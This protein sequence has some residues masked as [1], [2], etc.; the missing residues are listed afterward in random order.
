MNRHIVTGD[1]NAAR[2]SPTTIERREGLPEHGQS[3][4]S[5]QA[6]HDAILDA[7]PTHIATLD[8]RGRINSVNEAW[9]RFGNDNSLSIAECGLGLNYLEICDQTEGDDAAKAQQVAAGIRSVLAGEVD[10]FSTEYACHS[11]S[12][13]RWFLL[14]VIP[15][16]D[17]QGNGALLMHLDVSA[18][19]TAE[20]RLRISELQFRQMAE[21]IRDV[22]FLIDADNDCLLY[23]S[24]AFEAIWGYSCESAYARPKSW[25][26]LIHPEDRASALEKYETHWKGNPTGGYENSYRIVRPDGSCRLI[27]LRAFPVFDDSHKFVRVAGLAKDITELKRGETALREANDFLRSVLDNI[28]IRIFWKDSDSRYLG[29]NTLF[30]RDAGFSTPAEVIGKTDYETTWKAHAVAYRADDQETMESGTS[31]LGYEVAQWT[32]EGNLIWLLVSKVPMCDER[33]QARRI[34]GFYQ[35]ITEE[36]CVAEELDGHRHHLEDLVAKRTREL[37]VARQQ[38]DAANESKTTFLANMSHEIRTPVNAIIGMNHLLRR[39]GVTAEQASRLDKIDSA[40]RHLMS[41]INDILDLSKIEAN[42][43]ELESTDFHLSSVL[44][45]VGSII[46][47]SAQD[48]GLRVEL[49]HDAVPQWLR[50]DPTRLRQALLNYA[51]NAVKFTD[52]GSI[53]VRARLIEDSGSELLIRF[54]VVDTGIGIVPDEIGRVF[55]MFE[56]GDASTTRKYGGTGLGLAITRRLARLMGGDAG[57]E[58]NPGQGSTFWFS[59][60]LQRGHGACQVEVADTGD[61]ELQLSQNF[62][63]ARLLLAEDHPINREVARELLEG[64]GLSVDMAAD[65]EEALNM[66]R[67]FEYDLILMDMQ[68]PKMDGL[69]AT[70]AIRALPGREMT[71][72]LAMTAN[73][74]DDNRLACEAAGMNDFVAKPVEPRLLYRALLKWLATAR[75][76]APAEEMPGDS[77]TV[78]G[79][80]ATAVRAAM[81]VT[82]MTTEAV[83]EL[84]AGVHGLNSARGLA[85]LRGNVEK[86]LKLLGHFFSLH[87]DDMKHLTANL[88]VDD[89][90]SA[91]RLLHTLRGTGATLG[92]DKLAAMVGNLENHLQ[93][94]PQGRIRF[95]A[96]RSEI[97]AISSELDRLV[98]ALSPLLPTSPQTTMASPDGRQATPEDFQARSNNLSAS[99]LAD[100]PS[101]GQDDLTRPTVLIVDDSPENLIVLC[102]LLQPLYRVQSAASGESALRFANTQ[103][104]PALILL[105]VMMPDVDGYE[106]FKR[107]H[108]MEGTRQI[109][110]IFLTAMDSAQAQLRGFEIGAADYI[111]KP[112]LPAVV[113]A[114]VHMQL[115]LKHARER[116]HDQNDKLEEEVTRRI[117]ENELTQEVSIRALARL[118]ETRDPETGDHI[119]RT[120]AYVQ[121]IANGLRGA[122]HFAAVLSDRYI[123]LLV[124]S[125]PL[126]DIGKVGIPDA[127]LLKPTP[128]SPEEW[129]VMKTHAWL[130]SQAISLAEHDAADSVEFLTL[131]KEIAH[132]HHEKWDGS[133]YPD[134]LAGESIP[135]SARIMAVADVFDALITPRV[136]KAPM[137]Y[138]EAR[139][140][141]KAGSGRH[142]DPDLVDVFLAQFQIICD[143]ADRHRDSCAQ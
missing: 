2:Q 119:L 114:R 97:D 79:P 72:I 44:D 37:L 92:A 70:R 45:S 1:A 73:V 142:F 118:A 33:Q 38:A 21:N 105:D 65:G 134:A 76:N 5:I 74:F 26:E 43:Y 48:K 128:L 27:E 111:T 98:T 104:R 4:R 24:P 11:P 109:P 78:A 59:A 88:A 116:L 68:M 140:I 82:D 95:D 108:E 127:I 135:L 106:V 139:E 32:A 112:F 12:V 126:H 20:E 133:G 110:V 51:G 101:V 75:A 137:T 10:S 107:L 41:I 67:V 34:L 102:E 122:P 77:L 23:L 3:I 53:A 22:F 6:K 60:R 9:R 100:L 85:A 69:E 66:A 93:K 7:L 117:A 58:S 120:Q 62:G 80:D 56:Q 31:K 141:I 84:L 46:S 83:L 87:A 40:S 25:A 30:A 57:A 39:A 16:P 90:H 129:T 91:H 63:G 8:A 138:L 124:R 125:A 103:P 131:A 132:W 54:E 17:D 13:R 35:D 130:G 55:E 64:V 81:S 99:L 71:P 42:R 19:R 49:D 94:E 36:K 18:Q 143:I 15:L 14:T 115:E 121:V 113:L 47:Q 28:P 123:R 89:Q 50:G 136:Y 61:A 52:Q 96:I 29:C 86:Y